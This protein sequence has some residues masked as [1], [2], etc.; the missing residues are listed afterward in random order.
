MVIELSDYS[1]AKNERHDCKDQ[2]NKEQD[3]GDI[4]AE[5]AMLVNPNTAATMAMMKT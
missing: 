2:E 4:N 1:P 5:P 3:L